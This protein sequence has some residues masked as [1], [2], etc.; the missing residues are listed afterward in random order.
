MIKGNKAAPPAPKLKL[1]KFEGSDFV[2]RKTFYEKKTYADIK[3]I[4]VA[5][6]FLGSTLEA[7]EIVVG[8]IGPNKAPTVIKAIY[9]INVNTGGTFTIVTPLRII[10]NG[11][12]NEI[13]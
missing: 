2:I 6:K 3:P 5:W 8:N 10:T 12:D 4:E 7:K 13:S 1:K 11:I 9:I